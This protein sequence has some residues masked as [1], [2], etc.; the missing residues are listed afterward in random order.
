MGEYWELRD[1]GA[2]RISSDPRRE[3]ALDYKGTPN[4]DQILAL[5]KLAELH[6]NSSVVIED[7][8]NTELELGKRGDVTALKSP[9]DLSRILRGQGR[10]QS[11]AAQFHESLDEN[12]YGISQMV[13]NARYPASASDLMKKSRYPGDEEEIK[14]WVLDDGTLIHVP[15]TH[16]KIISNATNKK[17]NMYDAIDDGLVRVGSKIGGEMYLNFSGTPS[18]AQMK[19]VIDI[20]RKHGTNKL[21]Y[22]SGDDEDAFSIRSYQDI[23]NV[24]KNGTFPEQ[25]LAAQFHESL[26]EAMEEDMLKLREDLKPI[27]VELFEGDPFHWVERDS[28]VWKSRFGVDKYLTAGA[29][30]VSIEKKVR[31]LQKL[32]GTLLQKYGNDRGYLEML[33][34]AMSEREP[35]NSFDGFKSNDYLYGTRMHSSHEGIELVFEAAL[36][37]LYNVSETIYVSDSD[38]L[39][40]W[41]ELAKGI[42]RVGNVVYPRSERF[43]PDVVQLLEH[44]IIDTIDMEDEAEEEME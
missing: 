24:M 31:D 18:N 38:V 36:D 5:Q 1:T 44:A 13:K 11:L 42:K 22:D 41:E 6:H 27:L 33:I 16:D 7:E 20:A 2:I 39:D 12:E 28:M 40:R 43:T 14:F 21:W 37:P 34:E 15:Y 8:A 25:S 19:A 35:L 23:M 30:L 3:L 32:A 29:P 26:E 4:T 17:Y 9:K 10:H